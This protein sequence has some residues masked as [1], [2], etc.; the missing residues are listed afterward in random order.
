MLFG[1]LWGFLFGWI[2][3]LWFVLS[4]GEAIS[5]SGIITSTVSSAG[6]DFSHAVCNVVFLCVFGD[7]WLKTLRRT[8]EKF[9]I[10]Q[11]SQLRKL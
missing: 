6:M 10:F 4:L 8:S 1:F 5:F 2:M 3:N 7:A 11:G 9:A